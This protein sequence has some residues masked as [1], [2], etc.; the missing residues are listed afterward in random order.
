MGL[1]LCC[2]NSGTPWTLTRCFSCIR[3]LYTL[4]LVTMLLRGEMRVFYVQKR[5]VRW[6]SN[7]TSLQSY[8]CVF[9]D[10]RIMTFPPI[11]I[12]RTLLCGPAHT[13]LLTIN[14]DLHCYHTGNNFH[15]YTEVHKTAKFD[16][17]SF[18]IGA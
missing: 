8:I 15:I 13:K 6:L 4:Y 3:L 12:F 1:I 11:S 16:K 2:F 14:K 10:K 9:V 5:I 18:Y 7:M 17:H